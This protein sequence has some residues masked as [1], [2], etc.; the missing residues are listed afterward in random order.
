MSHEI[1]DFE[2]RV[3]FTQAVQNYNGEIDIGE[4]SQVCKDFGVEPA[5]ADIRYLLNMLN[6]NQSETINFKEF[7]K[8]CKILNIL[9]ASRVEERKTT[10]EEELRMWFIAADMNESGKITKS[11]LQ[12]AMKN[13]GEDLSESE[14]EALI[15]HLDI[16]R[17]GKLSIS[18]FLLLA[19]SPTDEK[20]PNYSVIPQLES[21]IRAIFSS[22]DIHYDGEADINE[23]PHLCEGFGVNPTSTDIKFILDMLKLSNRKNVNFNEFKRFSRILK[24]LIAIH[25]DGRE[26]TEQEKLRMA[27]LAVDA[28]GDGKISTSELRRAMVDTGS[29]MK[30]SEL[31]ELVDQLK[32]YQDGKI[33]YSEFLKLKYLSI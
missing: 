25:N 22:Y 30:T 8:F 19:G 4:I 23:V 31:E 9:M 13:G 18:E 7:N 2:L 26:P 5:F 11:E 12:Q 14:L 1:N 16:D 24:E 20:I 29:T 3:I 28:H 27:F 6:I 15:N 10:K 21:E 32:I 33:K 17:D